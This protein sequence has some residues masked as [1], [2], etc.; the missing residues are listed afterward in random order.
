MPNSFT[1][2][3]IET[4]SPSHKDINLVLIYAFHL[5]SIS[6]GYLFFNIKFYCEYFLYL[7]NFERDEKQDMFLKNE[8]F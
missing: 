6:K 5:I 8:M 7:S 3:E 1:S 4:F 2:L